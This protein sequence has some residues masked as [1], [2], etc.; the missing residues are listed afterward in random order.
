MEQIFIEKALQVHGDKYGYNQIDYK[1]SY[2]KVKIYCKK[3]KK[4]FEQIPNNHLNG[5]GCPICGGKQKLTLKEFIE[6]A[7]E[8][9]GDK[10]GYDEVDYVDSQTKVK[11][12]CKEC[13]KYFWQ[14][15]S[16]H[17][18]GR[19]CPIC[20]YKK[21]AGSRALTME[22]FMK[23]A[24]KV[25]GLN[26]VYHNFCYKNAHAKSTILCPKH[27]EFL[28][29]P[30]NHLQGQGCPKCGR[31]KQAG[32][33]VLTSQDFIK[34][35]QK[36]HGNKYGYDEVTYVDSQTKVKVYCNK[37]KKYLWQTPSNH[38]QGHGCPN[39]ARER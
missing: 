27:G 33:K 12:Y 6:R 9:H 39:C 17:L 14:V 18:Q 13:K 36:K 31:E 24:Q 28:Q 16:S 3:C 1:N 30:A 15:P 2:T 10:Y 37:C 5:Q 20:G 35:A 23:K 8:K 22:E 38:L 21:Q 32:S 25:H 4:Y 26:Y 7:K 34:K 29:T 11:I 19:G